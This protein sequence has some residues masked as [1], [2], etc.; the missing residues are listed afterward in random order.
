M[1]ER[2][3]VDMAKTDSLTQE[4]EQ[5]GVC[6]PADSISGELSKIAALL[7]TDAALS[8][9]AGQLRALHKLHPTEIS[10]LR[11]LA[12]VYFKLHRYEDAE[13]Q[14]SQI[15]DLSPA[16]SEARWMLAWTFVQRGSWEKALPE[17]DVLL[18]A[19]PDDSDY[20]NLKA[21]S[22]LEIGEYNQ[23]IACHEVLIAKHPTHDNW[24]YYG[25]ALK[26]LNRIS[27]CIAAY[28]EA[29]ALKPES[30]EAYWSLANLKTFRFSFEDIN[31]MSA[32]LERTDLDTQARAA[33]H[34]ALGKA[35][36][37]ARQYA[38][39]FEQ[40]QKG[41]AVWRKSISHNADSSTAF[42]GRC[43]TVFT[44]EFFRERSGAGSSAPD[45]IFIVGLPRSG[46]TL[47]EQILASHSAVEGTREL[48]V[49]HSLAEHVVGGV[50]FD[51][52]PGDL[53]DIKGEELRGAGEEYIA[54][55]RVHR[56]LNRPFFI[57]KMTGNFLHLGLLHL[58]LPKAKIVDIRRHPLG[59]GFANFRQ[60]YHEGL[61][62]AFDLTEIGRNYRDYVELVAHFDAVL[63]GRVHRVF[64]EQLVANPEQEI[65]RLLTY[66]GLPF[67]EACLRFYETERGVFT[68]SAAQVRQPI[69]TDALEQWRSYER[70]LEPLKAALGDVLTSYPAVPEFGEPLPTSATQWRVSGQV[71]V[72]SPSWISSPQVQTAKAEHGPMI[73]GESGGASSSPAKRQGDARSAT[74]PLAEA[75]RKLFPPLQNPTLA[76]AAGALANNRADLAEPLVSSVLKEHPAD[77]NALNLMADIARR[78]GQLEQAERLLFLC[79]EHSPDSS[80]HRFNYIVVLRGLDKLEQALAQLDELLNR[81]PK[82]AL[83]REQKAK[84]LHELGRHADALICRRELANEYPASPEIW[85]NHGDSLGIAG[86]PDECVSAYRKALELA[87]RLSAIYPRLANLKGYRFTAADI[88][89]LE[90][91]LALSGLPADARASLHFVLGNAYGDEKL[92]A[93]SFEHY[94]KANALQRVGVDSEPERL[95]AY[96]LMCENLFTEGFLGER[97]ESGCGSDAPIFIVGMPRSG[98]TLLEQILSAHTHI[99]GL[100]EIPD[101][102]ATVD[103]LFGG[104][105]GED[106]LLAYAQA[107][108]NL[109][110]VDSRSLGEAYLQLTRQRRKLGRPFFTDRSLSNFVNTGLILMILPKAKIIDIRRHPLDCGWSCF[111][112]HFPA[113]QP[114]SH[115]LGDI[116]RHYADYVRLMAHFE[117]VLPGRIHRVIYEDL[118][119]DPETEIRRLFDCLGLPFEEQCLRFHENQRV[120][121]TLSVEQV[122]TPLYKS[123][124]GQWRPYEQW[125]GPLK[126]ALGDVLT[127]YPAAPKCNERASSGGA[128]WRLST[129][130]RLAASSAWAGAA[131]QAPAS[132]SWD[133]I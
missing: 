40:Y 71:G 69:Y 29:I 57:D 55:T 31:R 83:F 32:L 45:P 121:R 128:Q 52:Y 44:P 39:S 119:A 86:Y 68:I 23:A 103:W 101:F 93:K 58:I 79:V 63:P 108:S 47:V 106:P 46:S 16:S 122:R 85:L 4:M 37:D 129:E 62:F 12:D 50:P 118:V 99:E 11:M 113:G 89:W 25:R 19:S 75:K 28:R 2:C 104:I 33:M 81:D 10:V 96:S 82:N 110:A 124:V 111:K 24:R 73:K 131:S 51:Q 91:Q 18:K 115:E 90:K 67:E 3:L 64:Y 88:T 43:K 98:S 56:K 95:T 34:F 15:L 49:L 102:I 36:E 107:V 133:R 41:N 78:S 112:T 14:L 116:G 21:R 30:G 6:P 125:L 74:R 9:A 87:P 53:R 60:F 76:Q 109:T 66:C 120:V 97:A 26:A 22:L 20:L 8:A 42:V 35:L 70:W 77:P 123:G 84:V 48:R 127:C 132:K 27:D 126:T 117:R 38:S 80:G 17:L 5:K 130:V 7:R 105:E 54:R 65:R 72:A 100:G 13:K 61:A 59:C 92:Y 94:A 114:F 1:Q